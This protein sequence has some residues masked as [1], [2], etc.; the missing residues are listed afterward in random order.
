M[1]VLPR[2]IP[3]AGLQQLHEVL[4]PLGITPEPKPGRRITLTAQHSGSEWTFTYFGH[5]N[6]WVTKGPG[7]EHGPAVFT[8]EMADFLTAATEPPAE[9]DPCMPHQRY[10]CGHC[11]HDLCQDCERCPCSCKCSAVVVRK[12]SPGTPAPKTYVGVPV[13]MR[14]REEWDQ[15][16]GEFWRLGVRS[17]LAVA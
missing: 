4:A 8:E 11:P 16:T 9:G 1:S 5:G 10:H 7:Y 6:V 3:A 14:V 12:V 17:T 15:P 2:Y 13:P